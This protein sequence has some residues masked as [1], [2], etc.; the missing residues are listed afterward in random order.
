MRQAAVNFADHTATFSGEA[1]VEEVVAAIKAAGY[2][3]A[4]MRGV[5]DEEEKEAAEFLHFTVSLL[6]KTVVAGVVALPLFVAGMSGVLPP[7][8]VAWRAGIL[9][10]RG[11]C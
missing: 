8:G 3:A 11:L 6:K 2:G 4:L 1:A 10:P 7:C 5:A 9:A